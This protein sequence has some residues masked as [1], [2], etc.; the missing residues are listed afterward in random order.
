MAG[1]FLGGPL[2]G[3]TR[4]FR[5]R[6]GKALKTCYYKALPAICFTSFLSKLKKLEA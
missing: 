2:K 6:Q 5:D 1:S 3:K 4:S